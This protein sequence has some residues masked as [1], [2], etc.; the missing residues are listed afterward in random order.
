MELGSDYEREFINVI[1]IGFLRVHDRQSSDQSLKSY[2][3][4]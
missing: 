3:E 2:L 4:E 1:L